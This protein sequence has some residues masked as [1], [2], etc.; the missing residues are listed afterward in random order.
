MKFSVQQYVT[1]TEPF[2]GTVPHMYLDIKGLVTCGLGN[3][4]EPLQLGWNLP[5]R[6]KDG[7]LATQS[8]YMEDWNAVNGRP[9]L[10]RLGW[11]EAARYCKLH[12]SPE[13]ILE[14]VKLKLLSNEV[15]LRK[16]LPRYDE[17]CADGQLFL[18]SWAWAV[19]PNSPYP[20][21]LKHLS[22]GKYLSAIEECDITPKV[23]TIVLRNFANKQL[24]L[25]AF[26]VEM[27]GGLDPGKLVYP[28]SA[29]SGQSAYDH[30]T[31]GIQLALDMLGFNLIQD[32]ELGP[33]TKEAIKKFQASRK[34]K[35]DGVVGPMT[36]AAIDVALRYR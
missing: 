31:A 12:L 16:R 7:T 24:L 4:I 6:R 27:P 9:E 20:R 34:L 25:N 23:G 29:F 36:Y 26:Y 3:L 22:T 32:G 2:E 21:M 5:W 17:M 35:A 30:T 8:E 15:I 19:G 14:T 13:D 10:A 11:T 1:F 28:S 18:H 33:K